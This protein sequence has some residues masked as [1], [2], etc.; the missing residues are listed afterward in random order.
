M[1]I[2][3]G[4]IYLPFYYLDDLKLLVRP[5]ESGSTYKYFNS[6]LDRSLRPYMDAA[7]LREQPF[8]ETVKTAGLVS[9]G[10]RFSWDVSYSFHHIYDDYGLRTSSRLLPLRLTTSDDLWAL[11][12]DGGL[13]YP[14]ELSLSVMAAVRHHLQSLV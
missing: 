4:S 12:D 8:L 1:E 7:R 14:A 13:T 5:L 2:K 3:P 9:L 11:S 6:P 10:E